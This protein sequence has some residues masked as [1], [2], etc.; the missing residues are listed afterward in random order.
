MYTIIGISRKQQKHRLLKLFKRQ[1]HLKLANP[2]VYAI[3]FL[4]RKRKENPMAVIPTESQLIGKGVIFSYARIFCACTHTHTIILLVALLASCTY[5]Q[6]TVDQC[7]SVGM[8]LAFG[9][10]QFF[11]VQKCPLHCKLFT[12][13]GPYWLNANIIPSK[14]PSPMFKCPHR[15][16]VAPSLNS[17]VDCIFGHTV[18][19]SV[20]K[21][22]CLAFLWVLNH[23]I[24][25]FFQTFCFNAALI[26]PFFR[27]VVPGQAWQFWWAHALG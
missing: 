10:G 12:T 3:R 8:L 21:H 23:F 19:V 13:P 11:V 5:G 20:S 14:K 16:A 4:E 2:I 15:R 17:T 22:G 27:E 25:S 6:S 26:C 1:G 18:N 9:A 24:P 7:F